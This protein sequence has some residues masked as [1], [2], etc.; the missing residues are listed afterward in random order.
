VIGTDTGGV[1]VGLNVALTGSFSD[2][3]VADTHSAT[4]NWGDGNVTDLGAV[5]QS[6]AMTA[7]HAYLAAGTYTITLTVTDDDGG[8]GA[9]TFDLPVLDPEEAIQEAIDE[10]RDL[11]NDPDITPEAAAAMND[12][13]ED[14]VG[15]NGA[16]DRIEAG[17]ASLAFMKMIKAIRN[18]EDAE[19]ADPALD[20][21]ALKQAIALAA[22]SLAVDAVVQAEAAAGTS[23]DY[24]NLAAA[25]AFLDDAQDLL[26]QGDFVSAV[27][28]F[29]KA[30]KKAG[31]V[32]R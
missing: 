4:I 5:N 32:I 20:L 11:A 1:L 29:Q 24:R 14:L 9:A 3:G 27:Q 22:E 25:H 21:T 10:L 16:L 6:E 12:A 28:T 26:G 18:L 8:A 15:K 7:T 19:A 31:A 17:K 13:L 2:A 23:R 30:F